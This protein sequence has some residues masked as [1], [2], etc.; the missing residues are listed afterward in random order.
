MVSLNGTW[1]VAFDDANVGKARR[2][3]GK[4]PGR[5]LAVPGVWELVRPR[6]DGVGWYRRTF[7]AEGAWRRQCVRLRFGAVSYFCEVWLNGR[8][9]GRHEGGYTPFEIDVTRSCGRG[10]T[11]WSSASST[12]RGGR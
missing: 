1:T 5:P 4:F 8:Q 11:N 9:V 12:R 7:A 3:F 2:W 10:R 6:Y